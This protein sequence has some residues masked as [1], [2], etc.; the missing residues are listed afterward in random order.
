METVTSPS[1]SSTS[2]S[3][4]SDLAARFVFVRAHPISIQLRKQKV[5]DRPPR[6]SGCP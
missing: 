4:R 3:D 6:T 1:R 5:I 2:R